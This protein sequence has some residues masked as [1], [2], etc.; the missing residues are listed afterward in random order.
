VPL[1]VADT[2]LRG[3]VPRKKIIWVK[4]PTVDATLLETYIV[5]GRS[6]R[7][8]AEELERLCAKNEVG[9]PLLNPILKYREVNWK[10]DTILLKQSP[11]SHVDRALRLVPHTTDAT[12]SNDSRRHM[13]IT[14][15]AVADVVIGRSDTLWGLY[16]AHN[17]KGVTIGDVLAAEERT[18]NPQSRQGTAFIGWS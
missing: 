13:L 15:P 16:E 2:P 18:Y 3:K 17:P 10:L 9:R 4:T 7:L 6:D 5:R 11:I 14:Q 1:R 12:F 8:P